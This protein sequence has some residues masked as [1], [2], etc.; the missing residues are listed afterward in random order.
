[1]DKFYMVKLKERNGEREY[2]HAM[3]LKLSGKKK[4]EVAL[5]HI[6]KN[7]YDNDG[8]KSDG[9]YYFNGGE[10][11]VSSG[12]IKEITEATFNDLDGIITDMTSR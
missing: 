2:A 6:A 1:M 10:V 11:Y 3:R 9:G 12:S 8:E 5:N 4:P 7:F